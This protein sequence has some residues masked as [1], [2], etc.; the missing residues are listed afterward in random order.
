MGKYS[1]ESSKL[2]RFVLGLWLLCFSALSHTYHSG[3]SETTTA[4][5]NA[6]CNA[7]FHS[8]CA[9]TDHEEQTH[10]VSSSGFAAPAG[11]LGGT[12]LELGLIALLLWVVGR[13][14]LAGWKKSAC[15]DRC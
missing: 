10:D 3:I 11:T 15:L 14:G 5:S 8:G 6:S 2:K 9:D 13:R 4:D 1:W 12:V 7:A